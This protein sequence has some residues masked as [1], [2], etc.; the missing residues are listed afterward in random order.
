MHLNPGAAREGLPGG[1]ALALAIAFLGRALLPLVAWQAHGDERV[2]LARDSHEYLALAESLAASGSYATD[3]LPELR[4]VPGFPALVALGA[5]TGRPIALTLALQLTLG[6]ATTLLCHRIGRDLA[7][8]RAGQ[9]A[10]LLFACATCLWIWNAYVLSET[11]FVFLVAAMLR[12]ALAHERSARVGPLLAAVALA[13]GA[14]YVR[15]VGYPLPFALVAWFAWRG[16]HDR[17][18]LRRAGAGLAVALTILGAWHVRNGLTAGYWGFSSQLERGLYFLGGGVAES[19]TAGDSY[20][21]A[22]NELER[23]LGGEG[24]T[25]PDDSETIAEMRRRGARAI[26]DHPGAFVASYGIGV[27]AVLAHANTGYAFRLF[28]ADG[29][30]GAGPTTGLHE[31]LRGRWRSAGRYFEQ[32]GAAYWLVFLLQV[33][34]LGLYYALCARAARRRGLPPGA[35]L[36]L[37]MALCLLLLSG[38][39]HGNA[40]Y[41]APLMPSICVLAAIG[42]VGRSDRDAFNPF[43]PTTR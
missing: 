39:Q 11:L 34:Q 41:R 29:Q 32:R 20:Y 16:R 13:C 3:G 18:A 28:D 9:W 2:F 1:L 27:L 22:R 31:L 15:L 30:H 43:R 17:R 42:L 10:A 14:A 38:G 4:R 6:L 12:A 7:G 23:R 19:R 40:R 35:G 26:L 36:L 21:Q 8:E 24:P 25:R 33:G 5:A 37:A